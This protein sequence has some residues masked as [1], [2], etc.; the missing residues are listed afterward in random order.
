[1]QWWLLSKHLKELRE[2]AMQASQQGEECFRMD[3]LCK[4]PESSWC[5]GGIAGGSVSRESEQ[6]L[7]ITGDLL[8]ICGDFGF[9]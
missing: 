2:L 5:I 8:A 4:G 9:H 6:G 1:M 7:S 3:G